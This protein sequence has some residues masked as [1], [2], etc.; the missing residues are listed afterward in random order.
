ML[1]LA[2]LGL[3]LLWLGSAAL[4]MGS[5]LW[6]GHRYFLPVPITRGGVRLS[7]V[8]PFTWLVQL[9]GLSAFRE[10]DRFTV[11]GLLPAALLAGRTVDWLVHNAHLSRSSLPTRRAVLA[12]CLLAAAVAGAAAEAGWPGGGPDSPT[13][14]MVRT[15]LPALDRPIAA[16]HSRS[17]VVN[18]PFGIRGGLPERFGASTY[19]QA[20]LLGAADGHPRAISYTSW[21]PLPTVIAIS[22]HPFYARLAGA[23][24]GLPVTAQ[25]AAQARLDAR[26]MNVGWMLVWPKRDPW[27]LRYLSEAGFRFSYRADGVAVYRPAR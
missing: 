17:I 15:S 21:I 10:A 9:P 12:G 25:Q 5:A 13:A 11:L 1:G 19:P 16:D 26:R 18:V 14:R 3:A 23:Q 2:P 24:D 8:L 22:R 20:L 4:A 7:A 27:V 6:A